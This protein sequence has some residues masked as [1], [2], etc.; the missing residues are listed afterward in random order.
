M[1]PFAF[2]LDNE[3]QYVYD[4]RNRQISVTQAYGTSDAATTSYTYDAVGNVLTQTDALGN[5]TQYVYDNLNRQIEVI[6]RAT[7]RPTRRRRSTRYDAAGN[8]LTE[9]DPLGNVTSYAYDNL[10]LQ[11]QVTQPDP[12]GSGPLTAPVTHYAYDAAGR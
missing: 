6:T 5:E 1:S 11:I 3:T 8:M 12:D 9:T 7:A 2:S 4:A 10:N